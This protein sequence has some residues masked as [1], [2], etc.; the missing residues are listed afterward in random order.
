[1]SNRPKQFK[2]IKK[3][4]QSQ[5]TSRNC[6]ELAELCE[7]IYLMEEISKRQST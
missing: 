3:Q 1:M 2:P 5:Q 6:K 7:R 4:I